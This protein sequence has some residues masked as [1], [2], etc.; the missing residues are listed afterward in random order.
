M[1]E[2]IVEIRRDDGT[3]EGFRCVGMWPPRTG[4][5]YM[6]CT[7]SFLQANEDQPHSCS[8]WKKIEDVSRYSVQ[9][10]LPADDQDQKRPSIL[11]V[12]GIV[13]FG[14]ILSATVVLFV[15]SQKLDS[16]ENKMELTMAT[17]DGLGRSHL[18]LSAAFIATH[19]GEGPAQY[20]DGQTTRTV[21]W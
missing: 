9:A 3:V 5:F 12:W 17:L 7:G 19:R 20:W 13:L 10:P 18:D 14:L 1:S 6:A 8:I 15:E 11:P 2:T 4:E 16:L 21:G